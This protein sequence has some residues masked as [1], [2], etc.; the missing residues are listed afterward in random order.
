MKGKVYLVGAGPGDPEL[1]TL[2]AVR[3][4]Q[5]AEVVLYD[6]L[7]SPAVLELVHPLAQ[8]HYVGK[9]RGEQSGSR[10]RSSPCCWPTPA[11]VER[12]CGS[13]GAIR[14]SMGGG[15]RSGRS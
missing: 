10:G 12:W 15:A 13:K 9:E 3:V 1:L 2:R 7:V 6:R 11:P 14:W 8:L 5:E 4:L